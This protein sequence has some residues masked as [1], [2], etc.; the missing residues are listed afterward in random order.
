M[1]ETLVGHFIPPSLKDAGTDNRAERFKK[2]FSTRFCKRSGM[3]ED[4]WL[5]LML[6][7]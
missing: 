3:K 5:V 4:L 7:T 2:N 1:M 6:I